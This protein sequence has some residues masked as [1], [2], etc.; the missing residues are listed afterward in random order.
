VIFVTDIPASGI[1]GLNPSIFIAFMRYYE[2]LMVSLLSIP[3]FK[4]KRAVQRL[5]LFHRDRNILYDRWVL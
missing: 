5:F 1:Y 2:C 4:F 3:T